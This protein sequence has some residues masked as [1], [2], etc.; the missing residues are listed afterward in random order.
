MCGIRRRLARVLDALVRRAVLAQPDRVVRV[1]EDRADL[2]QRRHAQRIARVVGER[3]EGAD[4]RQMSRRAARC[5]WRSRSC[6]TR[7]RRSGCS[8]RRSVARERRAARP[9]GE[10]RAGEV[11]RAADDLG[12]GGRQRLDRLLRRLARGDRSRPWR[13]CAAMNAAA[14]AAQLAG[15]SPC[16]RR[17]NSAREL[18]V[19]RTIARRSARSIPARGRRRARAR[20]RSRRS[21][22]GSRTAGSS[23]R[24]P[25]GSRRPPSRRARRRAPRPCRAL[26]GAP[27]PITVLQQ[28]SVG[29]SVTACADAIARPPRRRRG[30]RRAGR[31]ASRRPRNGAACRR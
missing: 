15:S 29:R 11:G 8:C 31:R 2:H 9:V 14:V 5:R 24:A 7:A 17:V 30:R 12:Q 26:V 19:L 4:E 23:S 28:I 25:R 3:E 20:P 18:R 16:V 1:D 21:P 13:A 22:A 27:L 6:R 10:H